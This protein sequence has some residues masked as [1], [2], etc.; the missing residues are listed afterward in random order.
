MA[1]LEA[2]SPMTE[3]ETRIE[4]LNEQIERAHHIRNVAQNLSDRVYGMTGL[5]DD[6][7]KPS[8]DYSTGVLG[9]LALRLDQLDQLQSET[10]ELLN[11]LAKGI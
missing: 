2:I 3:M 11:H 1:T 6:K 5:G 4:F 8:K 7:A 9:T 10:I